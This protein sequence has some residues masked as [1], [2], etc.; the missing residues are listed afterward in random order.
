MDKTAEEIKAS[1]Q[2]SY[3]TVKAIQG[4][5]ESA[6]RDLLYSMDVL[7]T[8]YKIAPAGSYE[9]AFDWDDSIVNDPAARKLLFWSYV[10]AG[11]FPYA[12]YLVEFEGYSEDEAAEVVRQA[13]AESG[14]DEPLRFSALGDA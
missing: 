12:R 11:K 9:A 5:L 14:A 1:K 6:L 4:A 10:Q 2:R 13:R 3:S 7:A 8:V